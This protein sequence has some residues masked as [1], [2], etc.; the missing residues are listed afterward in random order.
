MWLKKLFFITVVLNGFTKTEKCKNYK[1]KGGYAKAYPATF[2][3]QFAII[4]RRSMRS[5]V[6]DMVTVIDNL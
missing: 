6:R 1:D 5:M 2:A 3:E 4:T